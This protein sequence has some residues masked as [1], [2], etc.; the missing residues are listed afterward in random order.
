LKCE[1]LLL[2]L[3]YE[4]G[5]FVVTDAGTP[6]GSVMGIEADAIDFVHT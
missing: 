5:H 4:V 3:E 2:P 6:L 1:E